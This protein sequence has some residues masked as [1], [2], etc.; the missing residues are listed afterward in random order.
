MEILYH[1]I[2]KLE[3]DRKITVSAGFRNQLRG[4]ATKVSCDGRST[5]L[6]PR[7]WEAAKSLRNNEEIIVRKA[8]KCNMF[9]VMDMDE[10]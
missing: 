6:T 4:E 5:L 9:V 8:D 2:L 1:S 10:Y 7:L 3:T